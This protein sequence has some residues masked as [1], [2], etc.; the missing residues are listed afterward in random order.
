MPK[1]PVVA[2]VGRPNVGKSSLF[3]RMVGERR[4]IVEAQ[5]GTTR[6]RIYGEVEWDGRFFKLVDTGGLLPD[7]LLATLAPRETAE[8]VKRQVQLAIEEADVI[9][10]V[11]DA[12]A[13]LTP[14]DAEIA[15]GLR[16]SGKPVVVAANKADTPDRRLAAVEF[17]ALGLG[18]PLAV[19]ALHGIGVGDLLDRVLQLL[20]AEGAEEGAE[21]EIR[22]AIVGRPNVGKSSLVNALLGEERVAVSPV[23]GTTRDVVDT[24]VEF[25]GRRILLLDTAGIRRRGRIEPGL[26]RYAVL[27]AQRALE[28]AHMALLMV[29]AGEGVV[30]Q[31]A[32]IAGYV[33]EAHCSVIV[34]LNKWD[35]VPKDQR[36]DRLRQAQETLYFLS[37]APFLPVSAKTGY[38]VGRI[39]PLVVQVY[40]ERRRRVP[41]AELNHLLREAL[42]RHAP[43][44]KPGKWVK[45]YYAAQVEVDP[46]TFVFFVNDPELVHFSY[47]RYLENQI[48]ERYG[49]MGTPLKLVLKPRREKEG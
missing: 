36:T 16:T 2:L 22:L 19:S 35:L 23:P 47:V 14:W 40:D 12:E 30:A 34:L 31:D 9:V 28:R 41:T 38:H 32:H 43:P 46:P 21:E 7:D 39:L 20:P 29:D 25:E 17:F 33:L 8:A 48:R 45:F 42:Q 5:P 11:V 24:P 10:L 4:A 13:G 6:D 27:R 37:F 15:E 18:E 49:F 44:T 1:A 26:E 3:N